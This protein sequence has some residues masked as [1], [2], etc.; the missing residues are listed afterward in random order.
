MQNIDLKSQYL[1]ANFLFDLIRFLP[2][3]CG[4]F[5]ALVHTISPFPAII[6]NAFV[7]TYSSKMIM[8]YLC[9][10]FSFL[11]RRDGHEVV[12]YKIED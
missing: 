3:S 8:K 5:W 7:Q 11:E 10:V 4:E 12:E 6:M 2:S 1:S 9:I